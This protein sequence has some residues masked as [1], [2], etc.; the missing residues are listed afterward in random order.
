MKPGYWTTPDRS[1]GQHWALPEGEKLERAMV[2]GLMLEV[3]LETTPWPGDPQGHR[4]F[5]KSRLR[6]S[7]VALLSGRIT[8]D[9]FRA[10]LHRLDQWFPF[11][12]PLM[13][14]PS[15]PPAEPRPGPP[16][17]GP[18][19]ACTSSQTLVRRRGLKEW[20][21]KT[22][23]EILPRRPQRKLH[24]E[25]LQDFL[26]RTRGRW[27]RVK[28]MAQDFNIDAKTAWEYLQKLQQAGLLL[29]NGRRSAAVRYRLEDSFLKVRLAALER[30]VALALAPVGLPES[31]TEQMVEWLAATTGEPFWEESWPHMSAAR[32]Q[33]IINHL[34]N[35]AVLEVVY[36]SDRQTLLRL[37]RQWL[38]E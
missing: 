4:Q 36:Q 29:H 14:A 34:K 6:D 1:G 32:R 24:P 10:L 20:L 13:P 26:Q 27:F 17:G 7:L 9:R 21:E 37:R 8:L 38:Q 16:G 22:G 23:S 15:P 19:A 25:G 28:E 11:Y 31:R 30:Q 5:I 18:G 35:A 3:V 33:E 2:A 12:Y